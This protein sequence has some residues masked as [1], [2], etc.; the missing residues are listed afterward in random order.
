M[1]STGEL[2]FHSGKWQCLGKTVALM[3]LNKLFVEAS[4]GMLSI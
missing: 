1:N 3:E 2:A 4:K